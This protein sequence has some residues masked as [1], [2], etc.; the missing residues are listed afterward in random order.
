[1]TSRI[2]TQTKNKFDDDNT[3][4]FQ[5]RYFWENPHSHSYYFEHDGEAKSVLN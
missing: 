2:G 1:M 3:L 4:V 5:H